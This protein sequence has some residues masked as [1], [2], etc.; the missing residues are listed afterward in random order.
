MAGCSITLA[1]TVLWLAGA[2]VNHPAAAGI[3]LDEEPGWHRCTGT[4][5]GIYSLNCI[6]HKN[7]PDQIVCCLYNG[8]CVTNYWTPANIEV[9]KVYYR[10]VF[11]TPRND[12]SIGQKYFAQTSSMRIWEKQEELQLDPAMLVI[13]CQARQMTWVAIWIC[14]LQSTSEHGEPVIRTPSSLYL[15]SSDLL[16]V[17]KL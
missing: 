8:W 2:P 15:Y 5:S 10:R 16:L 1:G 14:S 11:I 9:T 7:Y 3:W 12:D 13:I 6:S 17:V 4:G